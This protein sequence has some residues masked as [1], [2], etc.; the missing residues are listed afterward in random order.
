MEPQHDRA[1]ISELVK[2]ILQDEP[3]KMRRLAEL[4]H[5]DVASVGAMWIAVSEGGGPAFSFELPN[6]VRELARQYCKTSF[7]DI[8]EGDLVLFLDGPDSIQDTEA[9]KEAILECLPRGSV[10]ARFS[11]LKD[12]SAV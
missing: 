10:L 11:N 9:L 5:I 4:F 6:I 1:V 7:A 8:F 2:A 3:I 12:T